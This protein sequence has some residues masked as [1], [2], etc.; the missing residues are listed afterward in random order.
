MNI[1]H[2]VGENDELYIRY[3]IVGTNHIRETEELCEVVRALEDERDRLRE[4]LEKM[5]DTEKAGVV[6]YEIGTMQDIARKALQE[7][8]DAKEQIRYL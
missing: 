4:A 6:T 1:E 7:D 2:T 8:R 3:G 5:L